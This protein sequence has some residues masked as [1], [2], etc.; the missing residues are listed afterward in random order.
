M[1]Y[2]FR[3]SDPIAENI[4]HLDNARLATRRWFYFVPAVGKPQ[5]LVHAI[6]SEML[7]VLPGEK[8]VYLP[9]QQLHQHLGDV[10]AGSRRVAMQYSPFNAIPYISRVDAGTVGSQGSFGV[11]RVSFGRS[12]QVFEAVW[13]AETG[14]DT[15]LCC[16]T[17]A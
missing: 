15:P 4:L 1:F 10:L 14:G 12:V 2:S 7:D 3:G 11:G 17:H 8:K 6:E 9:W 5:K 16:R 13:T